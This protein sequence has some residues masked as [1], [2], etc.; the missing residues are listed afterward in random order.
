M[1][2]ERLALD[3][4]NWSTS[5]HGA[6]ENE[7]RVVRLVS[8]DSFAGECCTAGVAAFVF[9]G[10]GCCGQASD[11]ASAIAEHTRAWTVNRISKRSSIE[12]TLWLLC[13]RR[14]LRT[15]SV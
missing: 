9:G 6:R 4:R 1:C 3:A 11:A 12:S 15:M 10:T 2:S 14:A 7:K 13:F 5:F 8:V